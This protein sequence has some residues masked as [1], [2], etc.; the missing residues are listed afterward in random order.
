MMTKATTMTTT[1]TTTTKT[2]MT[3]II[4]LL[5]HQSVIPRFNRKIKE[6]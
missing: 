3:K 2:K 4:N 5:K 1:A 6:I